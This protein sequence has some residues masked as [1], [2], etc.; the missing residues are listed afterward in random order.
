MD[1][2]TGDKTSHDSTRADIAALCDA[3]RL[4]REVV[5][6][7]RGRRVRIPPHFI[8]QGLLCSTRRAQRLGQLDAMLVVELARLS[9]RRVVWEPVR[10]LP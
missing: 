9:G 1:D 2:V 7:M 8:P 4:K 5:A 3:E 6:L 10:V